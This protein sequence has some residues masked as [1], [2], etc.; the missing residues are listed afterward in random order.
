MRKLVQKQLFLLGVLLAFCASLQAKSLLNGSDSLKNAILV[1]PIVENATTLHAFPE[2]EHYL[3]QNNSGA[4][5]NFQQKEIEPEFTAQY[6]E[7]N[8]VV[9]EVVQSD[10]D[11]AQSTFGEINRTQNYIDF[12]SPGA[13]VNLPVGM[14]KSFGNADVVIGVSKAIFYAD[15]SELTVFCKV[16]LPQGNVIFFGASNVKLSNGGGIIGDAN[17]VLLGD[18]Q[19]PINGGNSMITLKGGFDMKT[20]IVTNLTYAKIGCS[21]LQEIGVAANVSFPRSLLTPLDASLNPI[22]DE[23][24]KVQ[25]DFSA[26]VSDWNDILAKINVSNAFSLA[27]FSKLAFTLTDAV[28]DLSDKRNDASVVFPLNYANY[29]SYAPNTWRGVFIKK[30]SVILPPEFKANGSSE[31]KKFDGANVLIDNLG[32][33]GYFGYD[34]T[35][36]TPP[37]HILE[38]TL[39]GWDYTLDAISI[40]IVTN[41][42][43]S[44][45]FTGQVYLPVTSKSNVNDG[46]IYSA[47]FT[48]DNNYI[49]NVKV[50]KEIGFDLWQ[51]R[52]TIVAPSAINVSLVNGKFRPVANL[53]GSINVNVGSSTKTDLSFKGITFQGLVIQTVSPYFQIGPTS[54]TDKQLM[55]NFPIAINSLGISAMGQ[56]QN[57]AYKFFWAYGVRVGRLIRN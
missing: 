7:N 41:S 3:Q 52:A 43:R 51:A 15:H 6:I 27:G 45:T 28:I 56:R 4:N 35:Q 55:A 48:S 29:N 32:F 33:S 37:G 18:F 40:Q 44:G 57:R 10:R 13:L 24:V 1:A 23:T 2:L 38:G 49:F 22:S 47:T 11:N 50:N 19:I 21:G 25:G 31:R 34:A 42:F 9:P 12:L 30:I 5:T 17:L 53:N 8:F 26:V 36:N 39:S 54:Y 14:K 16:T 46:L 20:G